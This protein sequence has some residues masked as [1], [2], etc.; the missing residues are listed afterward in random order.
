MSFRCP[1]DWLNLIHGELA[2]IEGTSTSTISINLVNA[3]AA[4][5]VAARQEHFDIVSILGTTPAS[6]LWLP[7]LVLH[8]CD[9]HI[10]D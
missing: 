6:H 8:G 10:E 4:E 1:K 7:L 2:A 3:A 9:V 5:H